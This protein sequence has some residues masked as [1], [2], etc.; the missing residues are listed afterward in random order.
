MREDTWWEGEISFE[1]QVKTQEQLLRQSDMTVP[2]PQLFKWTSPSFEGGVIEYI[3][4]TDD[5]RLTTSCSLV[6]CGLKGRE[7]RSNQPVEG[8]AAAP[9][10]WGIS[11]H[12]LQTS[13]AGLCPICRLPWNDTCKVHARLSPMNELLLQQL[14]KEAATHIHPKCIDEDTFWGLIKCGHVD[15]ACLTFSLHSHADLN[16]NTWELPDA[17]TCVTSSRQELQDGQSEPFQKCFTLGAAS[18]WDKYSIYQ[19]YCCHSNTV[20]NPQVFFN[21]QSWISFIYL[22]S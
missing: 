8:P 16:P 19:Q 4:A 21:G 22:P 15:Q 3:H 17:S 2:S 5:S 13:S 18:C 6:D 11:F 10:S 14:K 9:V 12:I 7:P 1:K 20:P